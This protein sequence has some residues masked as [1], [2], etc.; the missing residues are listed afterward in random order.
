MGDDQDAIALI[1]QAIVMLTKFYKTNNI[2]LSLAQKSEPNYTIDEDKAPE[3]VWEGANYGGR[4]SESG[5]VIAIL[6]MIIE[7]LEMEMKT[8]RKE[9]AS[10]QK[11]YLA[12][13]AAMKAELDDQVATKTASEV[14]LADIKAKIQDE[15]SF[16]AS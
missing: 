9:D 5:G 12:Q 6:S 1:Q 8:A 7:D 10:A 4:M 15:E 13:N 14:E 2:P 16:K 11:D 3:T